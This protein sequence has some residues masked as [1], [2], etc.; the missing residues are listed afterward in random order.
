MCR[1]YGYLSEEPTRV[2]CGLV[3]AQN[4]MWVQ[5]KNDAQGRTNSDGWGLAHFSDGLPR[6]EKRVASAA[7]DRSFV[8]TVSS[9]YTR[10]LV[11]HV[12][13]ATVGSVRIENVHPFVAGRW[14]FAHNG[15]IR[16]FRRIEQQL[17]DETPASL[18]ANRH[19]DTDSELYFLWLLG[20]LGHAGVGADARAIGETLRQ[21]VR[22]L[23]QRCNAEQDDSDVGLNFVLTNGESLFAVR[24]GRSLY[25]L[26]RDAL[27]AC[28]LCGSCHCP[29]CNA[30][31]EHPP[32]DSVPCRAFVVASEP[33]TD[34]DW[35]EVEDGSVLYVDG[36]VRPQILRL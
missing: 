26:E 32:G 18:L 36:T 5:S 21:A 7:R 35:T 34:E 19:G 6:V 23:L 12:R 25:A 17:S 9:V 11:A 13:R 10:A 33:I 3:C 2:E 24:Y 14:S 28:E 22:H 15:T 16:A 30:R 29:T 20:Q 27:N 31:D 1:L 8:T 4:S